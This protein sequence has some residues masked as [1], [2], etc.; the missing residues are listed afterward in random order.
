M[1]Q[2]M[3]KLEALNTSLAAKLHAER[4]DK[5]EQS[6]KLNNLSAQKEIRRYQAKIE[7]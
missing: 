2:R 3:E 5:V 6:A 7:S 4:L 1:R